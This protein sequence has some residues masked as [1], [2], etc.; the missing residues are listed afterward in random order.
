MIVTRTVVG[1]VIVLGLALV[2]HAFSLCWCCF[3]RLCFDRCYDGIILDVDIRF[4]TRGTPASRAAI[5][6]TAPAFRLAAARRTS[7]IPTFFSRRQR[8]QVTVQPLNIFTDQLFDRVD[9]LGVALRHESESGARTTGTTGTANAVDVI[10]DIG[11]KIVVD[12]VS[13]IAALL[14]VSKVR[15]E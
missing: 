13:D 15:N 8:R 11:G 12:D 5:A 7:V 6:I 2:S 4:M 10:I 3:C 1:L 14:L 9:V